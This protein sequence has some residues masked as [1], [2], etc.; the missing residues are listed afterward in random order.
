VAPAKSRWMTGPRCS[1]ELRECQLGKA[2][3]DSSGLSMGERR[4]CEMGMGWLPMLL[5]SSSVAWGRE[6]KGGGVDVGA[7][8]L[9]R[10]KE[11]RGALAW[12]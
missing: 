9:R 8:V 6:E 2:A 3:L 10:E 12:Q 1:G 5:K 4:T 11:E 7:S